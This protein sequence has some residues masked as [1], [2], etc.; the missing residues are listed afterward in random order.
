MDSQGM[1]LDE[2]KT[3]TEAP[4]QPLSTQTEGQSSPLDILG[5]S[6][7]DNL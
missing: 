7:R 4:K 2:P 1:D 5:S 6:A 3:K